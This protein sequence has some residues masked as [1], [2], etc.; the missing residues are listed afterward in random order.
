MH[1]G[2]SLIRIESNAFL[3]DAS[4]VPARGSLNIK[5]SHGPFYF[6]TIIIQNLLP[7]LKRTKRPKAATISTRRP[8]I[9]VQNAITLIRHFIRHDI[10]V[11]HRRAS[12]PLP[13]PRSE[14]NKNY[15]NRLRNGEI[16]FSV[17]RQRHADSISSH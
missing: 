17:T 16:V 1:D 14:L 13:G 12:R 15:I 2:V 6:S 4:L 3:I 11:S 5:N 8:R 10:A 9:A 7:A